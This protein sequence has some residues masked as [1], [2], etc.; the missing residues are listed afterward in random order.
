VQKKHLFFI[1]C[2]L[3][4]NSYAEFCSFNK[5]S[6]KDDLAE[7]M[8]NKAKEK[9]GFLFKGNKSLLAQK[10]EE[11]AYD[12]ISYFFFLENNLINIEKDFAEQLF[13][14]NERN[15]VS[16]FKRAEL[17]QQFRR[18]FIEYLEKKQIQPLLQ[19][20]L[21]KRLE[22]NNIYKKDE[23]LEKSAESLC[24]KEAGTSFSDCVNQTY[25]T[26][27]NMFE[28]R[29][30]L[31]GLEGDQ[32]NPSQKQALEELFKSPVN[33]LDLEARVIR[34][35]LDGKTAPEL[36]F[37][38]RPLTNFFKQTAEDYFKQ[39]ENNQ[40]ISEKENAPQ[41]FEQKN[42]AQKPQ[43]AEQKQESSLQKE[44]TQDT[45][46]LFKDITELSQEKRGDRIKGL[47]EEEKQKLLSYVKGLLALFLKALQSERHLD[48]SSL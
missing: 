28:K 41:E 17:A 19:E 23:D 26:I 47:S 35:M 48:S 30:G 32:E 38:W 27:L 5:K 1:L 3:Q 16:I 39:K 37:N 10:L 34:W 7:C 44:P 14:S 8:I 33:I 36:D 2:S 11:T 40:A 45:F 21:K 12:Y 43:N 9:T 20:F 46:T 15:N 4:E 31:W 6:I 25:F 24:K 22:K 42:Q 29:S 18:I 13:P